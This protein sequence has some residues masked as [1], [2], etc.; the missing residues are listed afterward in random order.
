MDV[1]KTINPNAKIKL[2]GIRPGEKV[3]EQM[4]SVEDAMYTYEYNGYFKILP[5][6]HEWSS[7]PMR[8]GSGKQVPSDFCYSSGNNKEWMTP[9]ELSNWMKKEYD[10]N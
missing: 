1:A 9:Q 6:I 7:D 4:I 3:H 8:I 5:Q 2:I 10:K